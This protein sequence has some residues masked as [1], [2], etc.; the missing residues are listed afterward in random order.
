MERS[1]SPLFKAAPSLVTAPA[2]AISA[3]SCSPRGPELA[4]AGAPMDARL[5]AVWIPKE[6][7]NETVWTPEEFKKDLCLELNIDLCW[8]V[9]CLGNLQRPKRNSAWSSTLTSGA[10]WLLLAYGLRWSL[11]YSKRTSVELRA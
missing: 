8:H 11:S 2:T 3:T 9:V 1:W 4:P 5:Q 7:P 10:R 6:L